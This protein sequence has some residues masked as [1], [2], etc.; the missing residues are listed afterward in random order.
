MTNDD[1]IAFWLLEKLKINGEYS[2]EIKNE[3]NYIF[4]K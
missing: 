4:G 1:L 2:F 3:E